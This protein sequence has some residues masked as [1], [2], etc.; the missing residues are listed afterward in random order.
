[1]LQ[2]FVHGETNNTFQMH[3]VDD[4]AGSKTRLRDVVGAHIF[5]VTA[6]SN[7]PKWVFGA[8]QLRQFTSG[9]ARVKF[10]RALF[11]Q[12]HCYTKIH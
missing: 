9:Y 11:I 5:L 2:L 4:Q 7:H 10:L 1:M 12:N 6:C 3:A 8:E